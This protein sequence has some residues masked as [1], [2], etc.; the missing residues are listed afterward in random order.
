MAQAIDRQS[1]TSNSLLLFA[2]ISKHRD[3]PSTP[4]K[5]SIQMASS[6]ESA[7]SASSGISQFST[8]MQANR[9]MRT[10]TLAWKVKV[11]VLRE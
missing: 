2:I 10:V 9:A 1:V 4:T 7:L 8:A 5:S 3:I 11:L 6:M